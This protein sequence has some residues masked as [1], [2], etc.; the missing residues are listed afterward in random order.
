MLLCAAPAAGQGWPAEPLSAADGRVVFGVDLAATVAPEDPGFFNYGSYEHNVLR[1]F[2]AGVA[3]QVRASSRLS[4]LAE[5]RS[6]NLDDV[7]PYAL[8]ARYRPFTRARLDIQA[9]RIPPTFGR[10][11]RTTYQRDNPLVGIP[12]AF[13][14]LTSL[15]ADALPESADALLA[16]RARGWLVSYGIGDSEAR[17][18]V[19]LVS[20]LRWD[21]GVQVT[22][23]WNGVTASAAVT[24]GTLSN[25]RVRD[26]NGG[27]NIAARVTLPVAPGLEVGASYARG[28]FVSRRA[29]RA[30][31][32]DD[33]GRYT[34]TGYG[35]DVEYGRRH[36]TVTAEGVASEWRIPL[37]AH[38]QPLRALAGS[39][40]ARYAL[41]PGVHVAGRVEHLAFSR[42][43]GTRGALAW[44][45][46][47]TRVEL[48]AGYRIH[49]HATVRLSWQLNRR[50]AGRVRHDR[51]VAGQLLFWL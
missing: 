20:A 23:E 36:L 25:P 5:V 34:Q 27:R 30:L 13:Q 37:G 44:D 40:T 51:F 47:V 38:T 8:Y 16:M 46:P 24:A 2:R 41:L 35:L 15:R 12:L 43:Q 29:L 19:P 14:Y 50:D 28:A 1:E 17:A 31:T 33:S 10:A 21:T 42:I 26:D 39:L 22:S 48:G 4:V 11:S 7:R 9:G 6:E 49:R 45:A 3:A 32:I 18:G